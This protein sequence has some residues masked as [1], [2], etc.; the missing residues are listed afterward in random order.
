MKNFNGS[1]E[2]AIELAMSG[3]STGKAAKTAGVPIETLRQRLI[4]LGFDTS[5][6]CPQLADK[7]EVDPIWIAEFRGLF[8]GEGSVYI[9]KRNVQNWGENLHYGPTPTYRPDL[10]ITLRDDDA[11][12][13]IEVHRVL[14]GNLSPRRPRRKGENPALSWQLVGFRQ[15]Y[16]VIDYIA[17]GTFKSKKI[18]Q[19]RLLKEFCEV[20]FKMPEKLGLENAAIL[21]TYYERM[22]LLK[23]YTGG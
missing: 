7:I 13:L 16:N 8:Y 3:M 20:R 23:S 18:E 19:L 6:Y 9:H 2:K 5:R 12:I 17:D 10:K 11:P 21:D 22:K 1:M 4:K 14:G 15:V